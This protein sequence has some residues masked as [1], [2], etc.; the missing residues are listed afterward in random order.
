MQNNK[1]NFSCKAPF[2]LDN[3]FVFGIQMKPKKKVQHISFWDK[4]SKI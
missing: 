1:I 4:K 2:D 3:L